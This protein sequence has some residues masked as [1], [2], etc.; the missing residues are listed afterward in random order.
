MRKFEL[1]SFRSW[2]A[3]LRFDYDQ[4]AETSKEDYGNSVSTL[5]LPIIVT[6]LWFG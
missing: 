3:S 2:S 4:V 1:V 5:T 6:F